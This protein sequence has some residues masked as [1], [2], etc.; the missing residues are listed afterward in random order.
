[1]SGFYLRGALVEFRPTFLIP[2]PNVIIFQFNPET[3]THSW[4]AAQGIAAEKGA[5]SS[6]P[7]AVKGKPGESFSFTLAMDAGD[8]I[9]DG[10]IVAQGIATLSGV[11]T[12]LAA[13]ELLQ[14]PVPASGGDLLGSVSAGAAAGAAAAA[15]GGAAA[16]QRPVP[17]GQVPT[18]LFVWGPGRI[19]PVRVSDLKITERLYDQF[20]N[21]TRAE[22]A[23]TLKVLTPE[24]LV[25]VT[26]P[27]KEIAQGAYKYSQALR[28]AL[29]IA[30]LA[31]SVES[32]VGMVTSI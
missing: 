2:L 7:L 31:N 28:E 1:M 10:S 17:D 14:F 8:M 18:V 30:N 9:A 23:I 5:T 24:E 16:P 19:L 21:P 15:G 32:V 25:H 3:M 4:T 12:R 26:G 11:Y 13:L 27:L 29:A 6:N 22:A 20:L